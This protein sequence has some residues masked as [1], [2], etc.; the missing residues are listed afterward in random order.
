MVY[1]SSATINITDPS[2]AAGSGSVILT[3]GDSPQ[4]DDSTSTAL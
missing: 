1:F 2:I 3:L 4:K